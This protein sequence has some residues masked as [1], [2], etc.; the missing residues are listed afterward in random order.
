MKSKAGRAWN[1]EWDGMITELEGEAVGGPGQPQGGGPLIDPLQATGNA[2]GQSIQDAM[3]QALTRDNGQNDDESFIDSLFPADDGT[4]D[5][6][7]E[8]I[9]P[10][11]WNVMPPEDRALFQ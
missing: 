7:P 1:P 3:R 4:S 10:E 8:G 11:E 5:Q 6:I 9:T 2:M